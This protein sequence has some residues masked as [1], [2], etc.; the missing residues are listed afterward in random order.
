[1][2]LATRTLALALALVSGT[3]AFAQTGDLKIRFEYGGDAVTPAALDVK[4]DPFC[5]TQG[6]VNERLLVNPTNKGLANIIVYVY[7]GK[8][9]GSKLPEY[10]PSNNTLELANLKCRFEPHVVIMQ[11]GDTLKVTNPDPVGHNAN[12]G[13]FKNDAVNFLLPPMAEKSIVLKEAEPAPIP[14][15]C[16][17]HPWMISNVLVLEHP[18]A[19]KSD[20][21]GDLT[22]KGLP[23]GDK[24][25]FRVWSE[26]GTIEKVN[27]AG[28][29]EEWKSQRFEVEI[30]PGM[31]DM[32][33]VVIPASALSAN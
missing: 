23:A 26:A 18:F 3:S 32:G 29:E 24:L 12:I 33:T 8:R 21:N 2:K 16:N 31:N 25:I 20:E 10:E 15:Q 19:A 11:T 5:G 1:M 4:S 13:F 30:K 7:T 28:K 17:I 14:A 27:V 22:I 9:G 6:L